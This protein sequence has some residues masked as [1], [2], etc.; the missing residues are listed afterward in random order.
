[1]GKIN[2]TIKMMERKRDIDMA[3]LVGEKKTKITSDY[4]FIKE[5]GSGAFSKV[6]KARH[7][8]S[9]ALRCVK[10]LSKK[11]LTEEE[12]EKLIEEVS[13]LKTLDHPNIL[14]VLEFYQNDK[15]FFIVAEYLEGG[16][17]FDRIMEQQSL[18][19]EMSTVVM[20][21]ILSAVL[22][23]HKHGFIHRDLKPENIIF[24][25]KDPNSKIK[26]IDFGTSC[27]Y[28]KGNKLK[29]KLG[30]PYYIAP[31]VLKRNYDEKCDVWSSGVI[32]YILLCGYPPFNGPN[33]KVIF[34]RVLEGKF[35]FPEEDW[36]GISKQ[37]KDLIKRMLCYEPGKRISVAEC[38]QHEWFKIKM[39]PLT[40]V[41]SGKVLNNLKNFRSDYKFQKAVLL[42]IISFFD[43]KEEKDEL[44]KTF[45][46]L[47]LDHDGQL[48]HDELMIGYSKLMG[49]EEAKK[50]VDRIFKTIDVNGTGAID[51]TEFLLA[52]VNHKKLLSQERLTQ[53]FKMFDTDGS[54]T[55]SRDEV[56]EFFSMSQEGNESFVM[57]LI[58][59]VD[60][61]GDGEISFNEFKDMMHKIISKV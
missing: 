18:S 2:S 32:M 49:E 58:E 23:L 35:A 51:F 46:A 22:Y 10:K 12:K 6:Y 30:T 52:T 57:E 33:D 3:D 53:V 13:I 39:A 11:D 36:N 60:K 34:Q 4:E 61:N 55:I 56:K 17:L 59:E 5:I 42:Y 44:L 41:N 19:E 24:E 27:A 16:E 37:A 8:L 25:T 40:S 43:L 38:V 20:E 9:K 29:K 47:D 48:T 14:K 28:E 26:V 50:E 7:K 1:M 31:E 54:G 21:Q 15:Y 45:K